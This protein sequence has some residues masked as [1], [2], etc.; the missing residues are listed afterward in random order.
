MQQAQAEMRQ[1]E[2]RPAQ[3]ATRPAR[4]RR[5]AVRPAQLAVLTLVPGARQGRPLA[6]EGGNRVEG[7]VTATRLTMAESRAVLAR[8]T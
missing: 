3:V 4:G 5:E 6:P 8:A 1:A 7:Q 2:V